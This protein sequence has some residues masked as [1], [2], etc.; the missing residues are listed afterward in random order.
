[1][2]MQDNVM[3]YKDYHAAGHG[4]MGPGHRLEAQNYNQ[5]ITEAHGYQQHRTEIIGQTYQQGVDLRTVQQFAPEIEMRTVR[6]L[7]PEIEYVPMQ[8]QVPQIEYVPMQVPA[9]QYIPE[10]P[11]ERRER[12]MPPE[13]RERSSPPPEKVPEKDVSASEICAD[14]SWSD[15]L[16]GAGDQ[17]HPSRTDRAGRS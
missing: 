17:A 4:I 9:Q 2:I 11:P 12:A 15:V 7:V 6:Q 3:N 10:P 13:P 8:I 5:Q 14:S 16:V 1:M